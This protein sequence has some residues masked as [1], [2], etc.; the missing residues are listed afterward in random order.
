MGAVRR[1]N[2]LI[3]EKK[4]LEQ[5]LIENG[6]YTSKLELRLTQE[7]VNS[8]GLRQQISLLKNRSVARSKSPSLVN[9]RNR[10]RSQ[11]TIG[12]NELSE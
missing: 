12:K 7:N 8:K 9:S 1:I 2:Y 6:R 3:Q 11:I 4:K 5:Q 10:N